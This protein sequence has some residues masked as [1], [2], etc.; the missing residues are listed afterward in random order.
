[1]TKNY[2]TSVTSMLP[3][4]DGTSEAIGTRP[5]TRGIPKRCVPS[6]GKQYHCL[7]TELLRGAV[8]GT[9][10]ARVSS[11]ARFSG[12]RV[13]AGKAKATGLD[14]EAVHLWG[15]PAGNRMSLGLAYRITQELNCRKIKVI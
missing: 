6:H 11:P 5:N 14:P 1:M 7:K 4:N 3:V 8:T 13:Q 9:P 10:S 2:T 12:R 15:Q